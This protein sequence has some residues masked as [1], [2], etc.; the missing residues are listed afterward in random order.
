[1]SVRTP[2]LTTPSD[3]F[4]GAAVA[5]ALKSAADAV[6]VASSTAFPFFHI[7]SL[8]SLCVSITAGRSAVAPHLDV[9]L[10]NCRHPLTTLKR[11]RYTTVAPLDAQHR[12]GAGGVRPLR[13]YQW[14]ASR[15]IASRM[16]CSNRSTI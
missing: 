16:S 6:H 2:I 11:G 7:V 14:L 3:N 8:L 1:M 5:G 10:S 13:W 4:A 12:S 15:P 9:T